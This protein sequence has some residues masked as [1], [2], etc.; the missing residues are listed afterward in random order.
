MNDVTDA[1][2]DTNRP[3]PGATRAHTV[4]HIAVIV[5]G[6]LIL[7]LNAFTNCVWYDE[8]YTVAI[9]Q[10][11]FSEI[12]TIGAKD[13]HPVLYY[14]ALHVL[15]L[16]VGP[17][18]VAFRMF[19]V[20]GS[21]VL[22]LLGF[23]HVRRD[24][25]ARI[26]IAYSA[27]AYFIP[28]GVRIAYQIRMYSWLAVAAMLVTIYA[29]RIMRAVIETR[30]ARGGVALDVPLHY[31]V[32]LMLSSAC[33]A[34][35]HYYGAMTAFVVQAML[36]C[37]LVKYRAGKRA[38][39]TWAITA[40]AAVATYVPWLANAAAQISN[41]S[42]DKFWI[43]FMPLESAAQLTL[44]PLEAPEVDHL[45]ALGF[46]GAALGVFILLA[47]IGLIFAALYSYGKGRARRE[48]ECDCSPAGGIFLRTPLSYGISILA[49]TQLTAFVASLALG[50]AFLFYRYLA[51]CIGPVA[52]SL[53]FLFAH[54]DDARVGRAAF[55]S[56]I[57][58]GLVTCVSYWDATKPSNNEPALN[59]YEL[60]CEEAEQLSGDSE[61]LSLSDNIYTS[62]ILMVS[63]R[64]LPITYIAEW[65]NPAYE[66]YE[67]RIILGE[68]ADSALDGYHGAIVY[69]GNENQA[70]E[71]AEA[72]GGTVFSFRSECYVYAGRWV[73]VAVI[74]FD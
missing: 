74:V 60:A 25:D 2:N 20:A 36:F 41:N 9:V 64:G 43:E 54:A 14:F 57:V 1:S 73:E 13:V 27:L 33:A 24:T 49:L 8:T 63:E 32:F 40:V 46:Y 39:V 50:G 71:F 18:I 65:Q 45:A 16:F 15:Y 62:S 61:P 7:L 11:P 30:S 47:V 19:S 37:T 31:W 53:A 12:W 70:L 6:A 58:C 3:D 21:V 38:L 4:T 69:E 67:P 48:A 59:A 66:C 17:N 55:A 10:H 28:M 72:H 68:S 52:L 34:Y 29:W 22:S 44:F 23:T 5:G 26:G 42:G 51:V 35:L 56:I